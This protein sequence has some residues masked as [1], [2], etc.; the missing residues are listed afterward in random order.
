MQCMATCPNGALHDNQ[1]DR[2]RQNG[3]D[4]IYSVLVEDERSTVVE[5][6]WRGWPTAFRATWLTIMVHI[7][8]DAA[9][10]A[11]VISRVWTKRNIACNVLAGY[12]HDHLLVPLDLTEQLIA[13]LDFLR[14]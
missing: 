11:A 10:L 3:G 4:G 9:V 7:S 6:E 8:I 14:D 12:H 5:A 1:R 2:S 13:A